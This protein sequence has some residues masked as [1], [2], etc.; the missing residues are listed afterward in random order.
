MLH[1]KVAD[2]VASHPHNAEAHA[3]P[4]SSRPVVT[5]VT[6]PQGI[7]VRAA[8][9][10]PSAKTQ[11]QDP[12]NTSYSIRYRGLLSSASR[13]ASA[14][15]TLYSPSHRHATPASANQQLKPSHSDASYT[16]KP[17]CIITHSA[18]CFHI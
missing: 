11:V 8:A 12:P 6:I 1:P 17:N 18:T 14:M 5:P 9:S 3:K 15:N 13:Y 2:A 4:Y 7:N 16:P 10:T